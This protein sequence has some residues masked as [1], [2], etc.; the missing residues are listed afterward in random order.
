MKIPIPNTHWSKALVG[1]ALLLLSSAAGWAQE[2]APRLY[3]SSPLNFQAGFDSGLPVGN[4]RVSDT[5]FLLTMP[6]MTLM[7]VTPRGDF[8]VFYLPEFE[9]FATATELNS[10]NHNAGIRWDYSMTPRFSFSMSD[11][12]ISTSDNGRRFDSSFLLPRGGYRENGLYT[13]LNYDLTSRT[14]MKLR[15]ENTFV[16]FESQDLEPALF[17]SRMGNTV[18]LTVDHHFTPERKLSVSYS[19][20][21]AK[22][23]DDFDSAGLPIAPITPTHYAG[24]TYSF[25]PAHSVLIELTGGYVHNLQNSY[26]VGALVEKR[27]SRVVIAGGFSRYL[28]FLGSPA[29]SGIIASA[30]IA[31]GRALPPNSISNTVSARIR[32]NLTER[33]AV[34][35]TFLAS[36]TGGGTQTL[37][38]AMGGV[39]VNYKIS[40]HLMIFGSVD[41]YRQSANPLMPV[42]IARHRSF[43]GI[44][45]TF[46]PTPDEIA[47]QKVLDRNRSVRAPG[48]TGNSQQR[49]K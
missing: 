24:A 45:Y 35:S 6:T 14:R 32:G 30:G 47:R 29:S 36:E 8:S 11:T 4:R 39:R 17:F 28:T 10:W 27:Y 42:S 34:E 15:Y 5:T 43:G 1:A 31:T 20:L 2:G 40:D 38:S 41:V 22:S 23:F 26:V 46:S 21:R 37:R 13:S 7:K 9:L 33:W 18:G 49:E 25:N 12:F 16:D 19:Y 48:S 3:K 44:E